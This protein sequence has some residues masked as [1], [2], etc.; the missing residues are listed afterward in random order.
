VHIEPAAPEF[1][2]LNIGTILSPS[3]SLTRTRSA[4]F[5]S[6]WRLTVTAI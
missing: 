4:R 2:A 5:T 3:T 1:M 6:G